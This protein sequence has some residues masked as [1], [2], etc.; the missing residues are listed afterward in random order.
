MDL[1]SHEKSGLHVGTFMVW[2]ARPSSNW[3][4]DWPSGLR[5][6]T[7]DAVRKGVGSNP[8]SDNNFCSSF[9][10]FQY[11]EFFEFESMAA[12]CRI[13]VNIFYDY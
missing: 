8:T 6:C 13:I 1:K 7:Q 11:E 5:R 4:S 9:V 3:K 10:L 12:A 2:L